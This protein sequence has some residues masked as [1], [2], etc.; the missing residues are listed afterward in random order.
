MEHTDAPRSVS[1][2]IPT[3]SNPPT[4]E[5]CLRSVLRSDYD[6]FEVIVVDHGPPSPDTARMLVT[7]FP[8]ELRL[9]YLEE[10]WSSASM[11]RNAGLSRAEAVIVAFVVAHRGG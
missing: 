10:P 4:L 1:V 11:A 5:G 3:R 6:D 7:Q 9:R 8:G 2:I